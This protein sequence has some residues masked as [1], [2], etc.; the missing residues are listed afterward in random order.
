[1]LQS[2]ELQ[3]KIQMW[4][5]KSL[6][7]TITIEEMKEAIIHLRGDRPSSADAP[8]ASKSRTKGPVRSADDMLG[9]LDGLG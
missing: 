6:D 5:Q 7:G 4:K 3:S 9:E 1:M 2:P 8:K